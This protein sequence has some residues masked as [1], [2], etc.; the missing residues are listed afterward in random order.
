MSS[1][2]RP[3]HPGLVDLEAEANQARWRLALYR[4]RV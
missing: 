2:E 3:D 1:M 4:R